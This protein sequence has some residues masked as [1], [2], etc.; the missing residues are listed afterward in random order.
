MVGGVQQLFLRTPANGNPNLTGILLVAPSIKPEGAQLH[1]AVHKSVTCS[2]VFMFVQLNKLCGSV[3]QRGY[4]GDGCR[5]CLNMS[6]VGDIC[7]F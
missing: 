2:Y 5:F 6:V 3:L 7:L 1:G 4:N